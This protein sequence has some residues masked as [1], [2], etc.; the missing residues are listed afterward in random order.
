MKTQIMD[1]E[2]SVRAGN[3][4]SRL[5]I[6]SVQELAQICI[7]DG[8]FVGLGVDGVGVAV[9]FE[10]ATKLHER[11]L[12][13]SLEGVK[14][15]KKYFPQVS[16]DDL[17]EISKTAHV[18]LNQTLEGFG[19][20]QD[21]LDFL[22]YGSNGTNNYRKGVWSSVK[23]SSIGTESTVKDFMRFFLRINNSGKVVLRTWGYSYKGE[24]LKKSLDFVRCKLS[25]WNIHFQG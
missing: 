20:D 17:Q 23:P 5:N 12:I 25:D 3:Q 9:N 15:P 7:S 6:S 10:I 24:K 22:M 16:D 11:G 19:F 2:L 13:R 14:R 1:L 4:L 21:S 18:D 8:E